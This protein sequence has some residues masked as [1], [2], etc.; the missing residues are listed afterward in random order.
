MPPREEF[1]SKGVDDAPSD[2]IG[3]YFGTLLPNTKGNVAC[4]LCGKVV[5][6]GITWF[7]EHIAYKTGNVA[8]YPNVTGTI[9]ENMMNLLNERKSKKLDQKNRKDEF[10]SQLKGDDCDYEIFIDEDA[11]MRKVKEF[12]TTYTAI[13]TQFRSNN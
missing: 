5:K 8:P 6:W 11:A 4:K 2:D 13:D 9:R 1:P 7:K 10:L 12:K 3:W